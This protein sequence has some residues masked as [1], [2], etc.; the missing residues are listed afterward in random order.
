MGVKGLLPILQSITH[1]TPL[2]RY[3]GLTAAVD[4]MSW[5]HKGVYGGDVKSLAISQLDDNVRIKQDSKSFNTG[6]ARKI[7]FESYAEKQNKGKDNITE[8][9]NKS[10]SNCISYVTKRVK[11]LKDDYRHLE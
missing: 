6:V 11:M 10:I 5:L 3:E 1:P 8:K 7:N 9:A 2:E 4:A